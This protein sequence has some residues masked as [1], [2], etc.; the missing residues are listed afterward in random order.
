[1]V[2]RHE[3]SD[4]PDTAKR[5]RGR[6]RRLLKV[7]CQTNKRRTG[8]LKDA[9]GKG[10]AKAVD[11]DTGARGRDSKAARQIGITVEEM[12]AA[13]GVLQAE[14]SEEGQASSS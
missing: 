7:Q 14:H 2:D 1:M 9:A 5:T 10:K 6:P 3:K 12:A 13:M 4:P 11:E 8:K